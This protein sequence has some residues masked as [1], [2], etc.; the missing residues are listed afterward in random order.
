MSEKTE[1]ELVDTPQSSHKSSGYHHGSQQEMRQE[2]DSS[3]GYFLQTLLGRWWQLKLLGAGI[4]A[5][6]ALALL[7]TIGG[8]LVLT[9]SLATV[10]S[11]GI[12]R[13]ISWLR[14]KQLGDETSLS[15]QTRHPGR[16]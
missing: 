5:V 8:V 13:L 10:M 12:A 9:L 4:V 15:P 2:K 6:L 14:G 7:I 16:P 1:W 3:S 11:L